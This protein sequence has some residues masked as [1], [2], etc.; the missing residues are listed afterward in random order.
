MHLTKLSV[1]ILITFETIHI[2]IIIFL[3]QRRGS[4]AGLFSYASNWSEIMC[5]WQRNAGH[6]NAVWSPYTW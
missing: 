2:L 1:S 4:G 3:A 6:D 5:D